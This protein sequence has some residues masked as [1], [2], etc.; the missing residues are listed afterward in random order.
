M[1][2]TETNRQ[3]AKNS[4]VKKLA[5]IQGVSVVEADIQFSK[6]KTCELLLDTTSTL[7]EE[8]NLY[9]YEK[10]MFELK[11]DWKNWVYRD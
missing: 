5:E 8:S 4:F 2:V 3:R 10:Y 11:G 9:I 7:W 6:S 1:S